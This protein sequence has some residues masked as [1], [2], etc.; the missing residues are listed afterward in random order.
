M[1]SGIQMEPKAGQNVIGAV[2][3][4]TMSGD[5]VRCLG[6]SPRQQRL[7]RMYS[8]FRAQQHDTCKLA[9]DGTPHADGIERESIA[10]AGFLPPGYWDAGGQTE[11]PVPLRYRRP[12][13]PYH[14]GKSVVERF[15][16]LLFSESQHPLWTVPG[17]SKT[18]DWIVGVAEAASLWAN[19][20]QARD[21]GG[22]MGT[23]ALGFKVVEGLPV[24]EVHDPRWATPEFDRTTGK[25]T[26][27]EIRYME[28]VEQRD[29]ES[30]QFVD[31][32]HWYRRY[33]D[34]QFDVEWKPM[35]VGDGKTEPDWDDPRS[36]SQAVQHGFGFCPVVWIQN[37]PV[38]G[39][40][41]GD[42]DCH[43]CWDFFDCID[44]QYSQA[45]RAGLNNGD[46]T[47]WAATDASL[48][49]VKL[50]SDGF[51]KLPAG[52]TAGFM[53]ISGQ[54]IKLCMEI[55]ATFRDRALEI[56]SCVLPEN[57]GGREAVT[58]TEIVKRYGPMF[59]KADRMREQYGRGLVQW[60]KMAIA[61][62]RKLSKPIE[63]DDGQGGKR[64]VVRSI[65]L[66]PKVADGKLVPRELGDV[67]GAQPKLDWPK[68]TVPTPQDVTSAVDAAGKAVTMHLV[69]QERAVQH[70]AE[71]F[72][73]ENVREE[74]AKIQKEKPIDEDLAAAA[75]ESMR[76]NAPVVPKR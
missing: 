54:S 4:K 53:E 65:A 10:S 18:E 57:T 5:S 14:L 36:V 76:E 16:G 17:D 34:D 42:P 19:M 58:A 29:P 7:N 31:V 25:V 49:S 3:D 43:G 33:I 9:W 50:G 12:S 24:C 75:L 68:Y 32:P 70:V 1:A 61:A 30:G 28:P 39:D 22:A 66:P 40:I 51:L 23:V 15:T 38:L 46:P 69:S 71:Y 20:M 60:I 67:E 44:A 74:I 62:A 41:D 27:M 6:M 37:L 45:N 35:P 2:G 64:M 11:R 26:S 56:A 63:V 52:S 73:V 48:S 55:A 8:Y 47:P 21:I 59:S 72:N 13:A